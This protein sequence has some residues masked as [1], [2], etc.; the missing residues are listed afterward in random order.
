MTAQKEVILS[1]GVYG[2]PQLLLLSGIGNSMELKELG[3]ELLLD[4]PSV[5]KNVTD[6]PIMFPAWR[7]GINDTL[8]A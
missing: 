1:A 5:G 3:I 7:L 4:L 8:D 6:Q 2:T